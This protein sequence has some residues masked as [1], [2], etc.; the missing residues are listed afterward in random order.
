MSPLRN[1]TSRSARARRRS[2]RRRSS[3][4]AAI[5]DSCE[6]SARQL[7]AEPSRQILHVLPSHAAGARAACGGPLQRLGAQR[8]A[9]HRNAEMADVAFDHGEIFVLAAAVKAEPQAEAV[10]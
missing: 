10:R 7:D 5:A 3:T 9:L 8:V 1:C 4:R 6:A 2:I